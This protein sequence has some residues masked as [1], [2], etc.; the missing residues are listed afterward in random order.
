MTVAA[1]AAPARGAAPGP[2]SVRTVALV[3][4]AGVFAFAAMIVLA[5][6]APELD[7]GDNGEAQALSKSAIGFA[8]VVEA[9]RLSGAPVMVNRGLIP[10]R[11]RSGLM[12]VT[13]PGGIDRKAIDALGFHG[14]VLI[15][16]SKWATA[17]DPHHRGWVQ[18][19]ALVDVEPGGEATSGRLGLARRQGVVR[20]RLTAV[21][22]PFAA[23]RTLAFG[24]VD[25]LQ[26]ITARGWAPVLVDDR[27][28]VVLARDPARPVFV[29]A[30]PDLLNTQGLADRDTLASALA[31][32]STLREGD[33][34]FIFDVRLNG[35]GRARSLA[36]LLFDPPFLGAV[37]C[38]A[39]A[40]A[41][42]GVQ[43]F[44]RFGPPVRAGR[45]TPLGKA[46]LVDNTA[47]LIRLAGREGAMAPRY[48]DLTADLA[49]RALRTPRVLSG[50]RLVAFLDR[51]S[52]RRGLA[53]TFSDLAA[54]AGRARTPEAA[55]DAARRLYRWRRGLG[56][57][58]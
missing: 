58:A 23:G 50:E 9:L 19:A 25:S 24:P 47:A 11:A 49:A 21:G 16:A 45:V 46:V 1:T 3:V 44:A 40:A 18:K 22:A 13:P 17:P 51:L 32:L 35:L 5:S 28:G 38:L 39:L 29:L 26:T 54:A 20:P 53:E 48:A 10:A 7:R 55:A 34:P 8:G 33:G 36:R 4:L 57:E 12:I 37:L 42:A 30:D 27:G 52:L 56:G 6:F 43:A 15:V 31:L 14:P 41:L 2:F